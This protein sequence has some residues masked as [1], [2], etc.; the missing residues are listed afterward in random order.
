VQATLDEDV[1][2]TLVVGTLFDGQAHGRGI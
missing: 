1:A 2:V